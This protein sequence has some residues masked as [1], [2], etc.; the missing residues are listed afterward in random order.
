V[1]VQNS[2]VG[3][4]QGIQ[5][6]KFGRYLRY[7]LRRFLSPVVRAFRLRAEPWPPYDPVHEVLRPV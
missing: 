1:E 3:P 6:V 7:L 4:M 5:V 2:C